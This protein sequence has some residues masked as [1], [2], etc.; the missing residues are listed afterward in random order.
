MSKFIIHWN[1]GY[2]D[3]FKVIQAETHEEAKRDAYEMW[4]AAAEPDADYAA[5]KYTK[6]NCEKYNLYYEEG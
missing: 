2:G 1:A 3:R 5:I 4:C 6:D